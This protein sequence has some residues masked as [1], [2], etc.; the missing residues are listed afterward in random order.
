MHRLTG[1]G[2]PPPKGTDMYALFEACPIGIGACDRNGKY[3]FANRAYADLYGYHPEDLIDRS[4]MEIKTPNDKLELQAELLQRLLDEQKPTP[5]FEKWDQRR[6]GSQVLVRYH[7]DY[8]RDE[9]G[10][11][12][13]AVVFVQNV[14]QRNQL[15][16]ELT[17][18]KTRLEQGKK[19]ETL[20]RITGGVIHDFNNRL[21]VIL[22][23]ASTMQMQ[24]I[25]SPEHVEMLDDIVAAAR[26]AADLTGKL[27]SFSRHSAPHRNTVDLTQLVTEAIA[28]AKRLSLQPVDWDITT[29]EVSLLCIADPVMLQNAFFNLLLNAVESMPDGGRLSVKIRHSRLD[30]GACSASVVIQ[31]AGIG[32]SEDV[33]E[34]IFEPLFST[35]SSKRGT[36]LGMPAAKDAIESSGGAIEIESTPG[37]GTTVHVTLPVADECSEGEHA[38]VPSAWVNS[39]LHIMV[40]D[41]EADVLH[42]M[43]KTIQSLGHDVTLLQDARKAKDW[44]CRHYTNVDV[45]L[46]DVMLP[47]MTGIDLMHD[48]LS[49]HPQSHILLMSGYA[50]ESAIGNVL[51]EGS[52]GFLRKPFS[53]FDLN[54]VLAERSGRR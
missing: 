39:A 32:M 8:L 28:L 12:Y 9:R 16:S 7:S 31:D 27:L 1:A 14:S 23:L 37:R 34:H 19:L 2:F 6:D 20:G 10:E 5:P 48:L 40:V 38:P 24:D 18:V 35:K 22:G 26:Q 17:E 11:A 15:E 52:R 21:N 54:R 47:G 45:I 46:L 51:T 43:G 29:P 50:V 30:D 36:G 53:A 42:A 44:Y 49:I 41:D 3:L 13:G 4:F 33:M 25:D